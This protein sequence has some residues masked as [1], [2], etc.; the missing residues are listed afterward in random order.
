MHTTTNE[1]TSPVSRAR[2]ECEYVIAET[3]GSS[4]CFTHPT[5]RE[6]GQKRPVQHGNA[7]THLL[8]ASRSLRRVFLLRRPPLLDQW[9]L[10]RRL[11]RDP[12][13]KHV[14]TAEPQKRD[15]QPWE[16]TNHH[17][18]S[19]LQSASARGS[20]RPQRRRGAALGGVG[21]RCFHPDSTRCSARSTLEIAPAPP[22]SSAD[23]RAAAG[24]AQA[25]DTCSSV[26]RGGVSRVSR[27][28]SRLQ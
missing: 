22:L 27:V 15:A 18:V 26:R 2:G 6:S 9:E 13:H 17:Q 3:F 19:P 25:H 7:S 4:T 10:G 16:C 20:C 5:A 23:P 21:R 12:D 8:A 1:L 24:A 11:A 14:H 28:V